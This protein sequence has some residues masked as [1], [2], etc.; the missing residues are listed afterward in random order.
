[1]FYKV[2]FTIKGYDLQGSAG[3][4]MLCR[5]WINQI[6]AFVSKCLCYRRLCSKIAIVF[7]G[8]VQINVVKL[9]LKVMFK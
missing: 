7:T 2:L 5:K 3:L 4:G 6:N 1:M 8:Y 9:S